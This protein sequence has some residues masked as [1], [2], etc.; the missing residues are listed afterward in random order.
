[1]RQS[2]LAILAIFTLAFFSLPALARDAFAGTWKV[3]LTPGES[4][5]AGE[6]EIKDANHVQGQP[7]QVQDA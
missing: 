3:V 5:K 2:T 6:K 4:S 7:V 1:M